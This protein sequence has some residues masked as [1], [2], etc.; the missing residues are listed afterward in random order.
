MEED[1]VT[2]MPELIPSSD[3]EPAPELVS[4]PEPVP[5]QTPAPSTEPGMTV[6]SVDELVDRL[7]Q[8]IGA[9][10]EPVVEEPVVE[11]PIIDAPLVEDLPVETVPPPLEVIGVDKLLEHAEIYQQTLDHPLMTTP[12]ESYTVTEGLLLLLLLGLFVSV[13]AIMIRRAFSWLM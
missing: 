3:P 12:F 7:V 8:S 11:E 13:C 1:I 9:D 2:A 10:E 5:D 4:T 6:V